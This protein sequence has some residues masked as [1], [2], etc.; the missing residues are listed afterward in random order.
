LA[1]QGG[2]I[3]KRLLSTSILL[4]LFCSTTILA[5][6]NGIFTINAGY[7]NP[8]DAKSGMIVGAMMSTAIDEAVDIGFAVDVFYKDYSEATEVATNEQVGLTTQTFETLV[9]YTR[10]IL[11]LNLVLNVKLPMSRQFGYFIRGS[12]GYSFL[13]SKEKSYGDE[14]AISETRK[15]GGLGWRGSGGLYFKAGRRS[16]LF[17]EALYSSNEVKRDFDKSDKGLPITERVDLSG[18]GFRLGVALEMR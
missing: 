11:P 13:I 12:L 2:T 18:L 17:A 15:F 16:T 8:K 4:V 7:M 5:Q 6:S 3:M 1:Q 14:G 10:T 9:D